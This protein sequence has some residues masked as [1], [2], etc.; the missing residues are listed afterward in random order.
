MAMTLVKGKEICDDYWEK[1]DKPATLFQGCKDKFD[2]GDQR[3]VGLHLK[4]NSFTFGSPDRE[5]G[6]FG[7]YLGAH[8][9][10]FAVGTWGT[11]Y[12]RIGVELFD[13]LEELKEEWRLD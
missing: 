6:W 5:D 4:R 12:G 2:F 1:T 3:T 11:L 8:D 9:G 7:V 10:K 13:T